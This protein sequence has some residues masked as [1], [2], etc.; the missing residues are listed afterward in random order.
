MKRSAG[1][2]EKTN[3]ILDL[4]Q[5]DGVVEKKTRDELDRWL[6]SDW[7]KPI[8]TLRHG[9]YDDTGVSNGKGKRGTDDHHEGTPVVDAQKDLQK[10]GVYSD[11]AIDG[12]FFDKM[13]DAVKLFQ[14]AAADATFVIGGNPTQLDEKLTGYY[15]GEFCPKTQKYLKMVVEKEGKVPQKIQKAT[16]TSENGKQFIM[17]HEGFM[18]KPYN[19]TAGH[20]TIGYGTLLHRGAVTD[21]DNKK[22][23]NGITKEE[24]KKLLDDAI[25]DFENSLNKAVKVPLNQNQFDALMSWAYNF[26]AGRL[27]E[28]D[29]KWLRELNSGNYDAVPGDLLSWNKE[30]K[31]GVKVISAGLTKR[32]KDEGDLFKKA[33]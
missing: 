8:P 31:N 33:E 4:P 32:R 7:V 30:T 18:A 14:E 29:V 11:A 28:Q 10:V 5:A 2:T 13:L 22:Y 1:K 24:A 23:A 26:G 27:V 15:K 3:Q 6:Q 19:D 25:I 21:E 16:K 9:E 12:W 17:Q 20:A